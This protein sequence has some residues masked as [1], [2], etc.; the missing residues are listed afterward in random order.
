MDFTVN[1]D[2]S[3]YSA[4]EIDGLI[5]TGTAA[6]DALLAV[7]DPT[8]DQA[9]E[10]ERIDA[11]LTSLE[12]ERDS[13]VAASAASL[14]RMASLRDRRTAPPAAT[15]P[16]APEPDPEP[17]SD[18][19]PVPVVAGAPRAAAAGSR[20]RV[21]DSSRVTITAAADV[22]NVP[23]GSAMEGM[24]AVTDALINRL[25]GFGSPMGIEGG[26][27]QHYAVASFSRG[28]D[29]EFI[30]D[31]RNDQEVFDAVA[32][33]SRLPGGSLVAAGGWCSPSETLY[34]LC[35]PESTDGLISLPEVQASRGGLRV[36]PGIDFSTI[37]AGVGFAQ[38]EAQA[39]SGTSKGCYEVTCPTFTDYRLDADGICIKAPILTNAAYPELV[40]RV[41][42]GG[43]IV[44]Q[45]KIS[46][47]LITK[48]VTAAGAAVTP[49]TVGS[50][51]SNILDFI[52]LVIE[53]LR[54]LYRLPLAQSMEVVAP[55]WLKSAIRADLSMRNGVDY[56]AVTDE[57][58]NSFFTVR[59]AAVQWVYNWQALV[60]GEEG[61]PASAQVLVYPSGT[62][63]K[64][65]NDIINLSGVYDA[66]ELDVN[67]YLG[68]FY[69]EGV[70]LVPR[71]MKAKLVTVPL[72][73]AGLT[74]A[75]TNVAT[76]TLT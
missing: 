28:F 45:H 33:E 21:P 17:V 50:T 55:Y 12:A 53:T 8:Q 37:Y 52:E 48:M 61:Y 69:E 75:N 73:Q 43:L 40:Q 26:Q 36:T 9:D 6:L 41:I 15:E 32:S 14:D 13:R 25:R 62:F 29:P 2:L 38:T 19:E 65:T 31:G 7:A 67:R 44:H 76:F 1:E 16:P 64:A 46:A 22:P 10:A 11:A 63:V 23:T 18:P 56:L 35:S 54:N 30:A 24:A 66:A 70:Q 3:A 27:Q 34:D 68:V 5:E 39:I 58:I 57:M 60:E 42:S 71:C 4:E 59:K 74:G 47:A 72:S 20:P 51:T 49:A